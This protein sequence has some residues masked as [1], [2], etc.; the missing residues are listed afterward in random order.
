VKAFFTYLFENY[1]YSKSEPR[2]QVNDIEPPR[3]PTPAK[4]IAFLLM[5]ILNEAHFVEK[6]MPI[7]MLNI[8]HY[9]LLLM[10]IFYRKY[11]FEAYGF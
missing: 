6:S 3:T 5:P 1:R 2:I 10:L 11:L 9:N 8:K 4:N 7:R